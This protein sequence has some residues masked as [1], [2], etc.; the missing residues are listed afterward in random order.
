MTGP[1]TLRREHPL[2]GGMT[3]A[4]LVSRVGETVRRPARPTGEAT[5]ALL[6]HLSQVGFDGAPRHLGTDDQGREVLTYIPGRAPIAPTPPWAL[7][8]E[9]LVSVAELLRRY[10]D[11]AE[12]F[13][14]NAYAWSHAVPARFRDG[15]VSHND[16][17][18]DN[19]IFREGR[20]V[21]LID[22][23]LYV[24]KPE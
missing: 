19:I 23:D 16:P 20:A 24:S 14:P 22:F 3:N 13:D 12:S 7:R 17:N 18:L 21:E 1:A 11:A 8:D 15:L 5:Q 2:R 6:D 10:H 4:G 9:A